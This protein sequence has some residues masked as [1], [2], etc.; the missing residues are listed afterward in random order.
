MDMTLVARRLRMLAASFGAGAVG[1]AA[2]AVLVGGSDAAQ[3]DLAEGAVLAAGVLGAIGLLAALRWWSIAGERPT[4]P[5]QV[6]VGFIVRV[7]VAETGLFIGFVGIFITGSITA[8]LT[9][10]AS[11]LLSLLALVLA[12][13]RIEAQSTSGRP[14]ST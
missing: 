12:L 6:Q 14:L 13:N 4:S 10:L 5:A 3:P 2:I 1:I 9:G 7:A 8:V 11:F